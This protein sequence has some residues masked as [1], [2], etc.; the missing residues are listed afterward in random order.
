MIWLESREIPFKAIA[1]W[2]NKSQ[3]KTNFHFFIRSF[4]SS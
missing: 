3:L 1:S 4:T 2:I